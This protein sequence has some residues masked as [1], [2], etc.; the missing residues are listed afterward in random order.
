MEAKAMDECMRLVKEM[1][2]LQKLYFKTRSSE[3]LRE[4]KE[5]EKA[6]DDAIWKA[7]HPSPM[8]GQMSFDFGEAQ[9]GD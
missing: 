6:V 5:L 3:T 4:C 8:E 1:R 7:E 9:D 2:R